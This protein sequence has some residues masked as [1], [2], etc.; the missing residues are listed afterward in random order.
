MKELSYILLHVVPAILF[1]VAL[2]IT[3][4]LAVLGKRIR[5]EADQR[6]VEG[7]SENQ[8]TEGREG[9]MDN[10]VDFIWAKKHD[11]PL[12]THSG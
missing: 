2:G 1:A 11:E 3:V 8:D 6:Y 12:Q 7:Q 5:G 4:Y 10:M 9:D